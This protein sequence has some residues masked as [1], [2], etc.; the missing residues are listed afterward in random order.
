MEM[1]MRSIRPKSRRRSIDAAF[2]VRA[3]CGCV[4]WFV[5][6]Y[7]CLVC[8]LLFCFASNLTNRFENELENDSPIEAEGK[9]T[10]AASQLDTHTHNTLTSLRHSMHVQTRWKTRRLR[11]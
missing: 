2:V 7:M 5:F 6:N 9:A 8:V 10:G 4:D 11:H 1:R 3:A